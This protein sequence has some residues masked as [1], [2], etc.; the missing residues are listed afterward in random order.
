MVLGL[1]IDLLLLSSGCLF[2]VTFKLRLLISPALVYFVLFHRI[3]K[4]FSVK[5]I[6]NI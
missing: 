2:N 1:F 4:Y 3:Y 5:L 6:L